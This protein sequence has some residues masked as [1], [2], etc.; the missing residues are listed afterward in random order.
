MFR[1][2]ASDL[3]ISKEPSLTTITG[4]R[5]LKKKNLVM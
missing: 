4:N 2:S 3:W 5:N 1:V